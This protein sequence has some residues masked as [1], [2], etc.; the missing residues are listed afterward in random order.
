MWVSLYK[1][2][3]NN[4][5]IANIICSPLRMGH[6]VDFFKHL[7]HHRW[8]HALWSGHVVLRAPCKEWRHVLQ[9]ERVRG[10]FKRDGQLI[11]INLW[12]ERG[13]RVTKACEAAALQTVS[14]FFVRRRAEAE[15][16]VEMVFWSKGK[17][18]FCCHAPRSLSLLDKYQ[19]PRRE[20]KWDTPPNGNGHGGDR[21]GGRVARKQRV[22]MGRLIGKGRRDGGHF[23]TN[24]IEGQCAGLYPYLW[25]LIPNKAHS[26]VGR[27]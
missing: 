27:F 15:W 26:R 21:R 8:A 9:L 13:G 20:T 1:S 10:G 23:W 11:T 17:L 12:G 16:M 19:M 6:A 18:L 25:R 22:P 2:I 5:A 14:L 3:Y 24:F 7:E 4:F